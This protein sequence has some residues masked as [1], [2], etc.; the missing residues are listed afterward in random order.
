MEEKNKSGLFLLFGIILMTITMVLHPS[1]GSLEHIL[2]IRTILIISHS[3]AIFSIP[4]LIIGFW[5][6]WKSL[7]THNLVSTLAFI[8]SFLGSIAAMLAA[9]VN[10]LVLPNFLVRNYDPNNSMNA[11]YIKLFVRYNSSLNLAMDYILISAFVLAV[12]LWSIL[13]V[14]QRPK[15]FPAWL[16]FFGIILTMTVLIGVVSGYDFI[17]V[18]G[19]RVFIFGLVSWLMVAGVYMNKKMESD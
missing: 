18:Q 11:D 6:I 4:F 1:G 17:H 10:G 3:L 14:L 9:V 7:G 5:G 15:V 8:I 13:I 2:N 12:L 16:G 19:F